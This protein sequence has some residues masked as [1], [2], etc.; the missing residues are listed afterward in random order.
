MSPRESTSP[1]TTNLSAPIAKSLEEQLKAI[2]QQAAKITQPLQQAHSLETA[3]QDV[4]AQLQQVFECD[5]ALIY[6]L[7]DRS[8]DAFIDQFPNPVSGL[9]FNGGGNGA[10]RPSSNGS[11]DSGLPLTSANGG[12]LTGTVIAEA[13][14]RGWTPALGDRLHIAAFGVETLDDYQNLGFISI[15]D[16]SR[17]NLTPHQQQI[18]NRYQV[19]AALTIP[20]KLGPKLWGGLVRTALSESLLLV[21]T[22]NCHPTTSGRGVNQFPAESQRPENLHARPQPPAD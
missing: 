14:S 18:L 22:R 4:V 21:R 20:L 6:R 3:C 13:V 2:R 10:N 7:C 5:R 16:Q 9:S 1:A 15:A 8:I 19:Q 11:I 17:T 12:N